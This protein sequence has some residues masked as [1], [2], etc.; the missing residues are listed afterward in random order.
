MFEPLNRFSH[1]ANFT[2]YMAVVQR[3]VEQRHRAPADVLD[4]PAGNGLLS[5]RLRALG[6]RVVRADFNAEHPDY[7]YADMEARLPFDD[8]RFDVVCCLEGIEHVIDPTHLARELARVLRPGG[9]LY[10]SLPNLQSLYS[11]LCF[12]FTGTFYQFAPEQ[13]RHPAGEP[14]DRGHINGLTLAQL[15]YLFA[16]VG[17]IMAHVD[18]DKI[19]KKALMP[20]YLPLWAIA[21]LATRR[22]RQPV[23]EHH[24]AGLF[25]ALD[26]RPAMLS[27]SIIVCFEKPAS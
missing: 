26:S 22:R 14:V 24:R 12:L 18:G 13:T 3:L 11:R 7:V 5:E 10:L 23:G 9:T 4:M 21:S 2:G 20:V 8:N 25:R 16:D 6:H 15:H 1:V 17:L 19:K 27:R